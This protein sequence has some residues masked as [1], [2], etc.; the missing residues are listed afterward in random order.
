M[1]NLTISIARN[2]KKLGALTLLSLGALLIQSCSKDETPVQEVAFLNIINTSP[3]LGTFNIYLDQ[4]K[5]NT[6]GAV[7]FGGNSGYMRLTPGNHSIKFTTASSTESLITKNVALDVNSINSLFLIDRGNNMDFLT[8]KDELGNVS[9]AKAFVRFINLSPDAP[10][11]NLAVKDGNAI[12]SDK[13]YKTSSAFIEI[14]PKAYIFEIKDKATSA[15]KATLE[16][17]EFKA[18]KSYTVIAMGL[19]APSDVERGIG[20]KIIVNQ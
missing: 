17:F 15:T 10:A 18:G 16:S 11:L 6:Q 8:L 12:V 2:L 3:V 5:I 20:G 1:N 19:L 9:S 14:E 4:T 13:A 7:D